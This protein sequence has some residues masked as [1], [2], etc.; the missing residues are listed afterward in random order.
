MIP[1]EIHDYDPRLFDDQT[2]VI[3]KRCPNCGAH[4]EDDDDYCPV[5][6]ET[7]PA[8]HIAETSGPYWYERRAYMVTYVVL[9]WPVALYGLYQR[10]AWGQNADQWMLMGCLTM[11]VLWSLVLNVV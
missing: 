10:D 9:L 6:G 1:E 11:A 5:C 2:T 8:P 3:M 7:F 4:R